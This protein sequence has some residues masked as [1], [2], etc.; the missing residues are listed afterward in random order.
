MSSVSASFREHPK[1]FGA[2]VA[3]EAVEG[4][5]IVEMEEG[6]EAESMESLLGFDRTYIKF[7]YNAVLN[8]GYALQNVPGKKI[9]TGRIGCSM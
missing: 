6:A 9:N 5:Y 3:A 7:R 4:C 8:G 2:A 1:F